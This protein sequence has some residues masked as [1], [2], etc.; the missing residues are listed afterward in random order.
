MLSNK[1]P[2]W[3]LAQLDIATISVFQLYSRKKSLV[4]LH[5]AYVGWLLA[6]LCAKCKWCIFAYIENNR[7]QWQCEK[8][9]QT[10]VTE[11]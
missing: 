8:E 4:F 7:A 9:S 2:N 10:P 11:L 3:H 6:L 5:S 1:R